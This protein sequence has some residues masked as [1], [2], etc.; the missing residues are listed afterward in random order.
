[1]NEKAI[2]YVT[3]NALTSGILCTECEICH[4]TNSDMISYRTNEGQFLLH[5]PF[6]HRSK[7]NARKHAEEMRN[8][9]IASLQMLIRKLKKLSF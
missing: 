6:W 5:K 2:V 4:D 7:S 1:M 8:R 9:K 3:K